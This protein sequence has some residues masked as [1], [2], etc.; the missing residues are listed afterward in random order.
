MVDKPRL[1]PQAFAKGGS[2]G[3]PRLSA[4]MPNFRAAPS[5]TAFADASIADTL[6]GMADD[7][8]RLEMLSSNQFGASMQQFEKAQDEVKTLQAIEA[9]SALDKIMLQSQARINRLRQSDI[10]ADGITSGTQEQFQNVR[11]EVLENSNLSGYQLQYLAPKLQD[12]ETGFAQNALEYQTQLRTQEAAFALSEKEQSLSLMVQQNPQ[13]MSDPDK[14]KDFLSSKVNDA[15]DQFGA[16]LTQLERIQAKDALREKLTVTALTA[17]IG[18]SP[19]NSR[20][21]IEKA[22]GELRL[23]AD[24]VRQLNNLADAQENA[25]IVEANKMSAQATKLGNQNLTNRYLNSLAG[26]EPLKPVDIMQNPAFANASPS[27]KLSISN[28]LTA[29]ESK[30]GNPLAYTR[31]KREIRKAQNSKGPVVLEDVL[32][33]ADPTKTSAP[34][35]GSELENLVRSI[36]KPADDAVEQVIDSVQDKFTKNKMD[37]TGLGDKGLFNFE[38]ALDTAINEKIDNNQDWRPLVTEGSGQYIVDDLVRKYLPTDADLVQDQIRSA[39]ESADS[40][41]QLKIN[42][43]EMTDEELQLKLFEKLGAK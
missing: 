20:P 10:S 8:K 12:L 22:A 42:P 34:I 1:T 3:A 39:K 18:I 36:E 29:N 28:A 2:Q 27:T 7:A 35:S 6:V 17:Q 11:D 37:T 31:M 14:R 43:T 24:Q 19:V 30:A 32:D 40:F 38:Q 26:G 9:E 21:L 25:N 41:R 4:Q 23:S 5:V 15:V 33:L 16:S 13:L